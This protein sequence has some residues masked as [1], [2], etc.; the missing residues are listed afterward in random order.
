LYWPLFPFFLFLLFLIIRCER[1]NGDQCRQSKQAKHFEIHKSLVYVMELSIRVPMSEAATIQECN[2]S[3]N[4]SSTI[5]MRF[6]V[7]VMTVCP[8]VRP[9][10]RYAS[11]CGVIGEVPGPPAAPKKATHHFPTSKLQLN[12]LPASMTRDHSSRDHHSPL[13]DGSRRFIVAAI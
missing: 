6:L 11:Y 4:R 1:W 7:S 2:H 13:A 12:R 5:A 10:D 9:T 3:S 8:F